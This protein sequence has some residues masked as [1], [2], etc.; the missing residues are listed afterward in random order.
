MTIRDMARRSPRTSA[1]ILALIVVSTVRIGVTIPDEPQERDAGGYVAVGV[2]LA[3]Y[4]IYGSGET[5]TMD[6][7]P[8]LSATIAAALRVDPRH[9]DFRAGEELSAH[10]AVRQVNLLFVL[11]LQA[12]V[13]A[14]AVH[15]MG[16]GHRGAIAATTAIALNH[17][18]LLENPE[19]THSSLQELPAAAVMVWTSLAALRAV[20]EPRYRW[21]VLTGMLGGL[22]AL[23]RSV[24]L[25]IFPIFL[26][27]TVL[28]IPGRPPN[29]AKRLLAGVLGFALIA[30]PWVARNATEFGELSVS[31]GGPEVLLIRDVKNGMDAYQHRGAWVHFSPEPLHPI[32]A[33]LIA[34]DREDFLDDGPLRPLVRHLPDPVTGEDLERLERRS[35]YRQARDIRADLLAQAAEDGLSGEEARG[36]VDAQLFAMVR[37]NV[38][39]RPTRFLRT[40][41]VFLYRSS[42]PMN[43]TQLWAPEG[44]SPARVLMAVLNVVGMAG[45]LAVGLVGLLRRR[46]RWF[47]FAGLPVGM[48]GYHALLTHALPRYTRP[49][50]SVMILTVVLVIAVITERASARRRAG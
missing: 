49:A 23:T 41:P 3:R 21:I 18:F 19:F 7:A 10:G 36:H 22:L 13:A 39:E 34:V 47:A 1:L 14:M 48:I 33:R 46:A 11:L 29:V 20:R 2:N 45:L 25:H 26:L 8:V 37:E 6:Y 5:R 17:V 12:G 38:S 24:F 43:Q 15:L 50:A 28:L 27:I 42:W 31:R 9:S 30:G 40:T 4:G 44:L 32:V 16:G 35:F